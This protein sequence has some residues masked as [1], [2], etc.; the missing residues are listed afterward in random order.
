MMVAASDAMKLNREIRKR[1]SILRFTRI[2]MK[3]KKP[4]TSVS[5][6]GLFLFQ[7]EADARNVNFPK[8]SRDYHFVISSLF[9]ISFFF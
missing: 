1:N 5:N 2:A 7:I 4:I 6:L 3:L 9:E 8:C